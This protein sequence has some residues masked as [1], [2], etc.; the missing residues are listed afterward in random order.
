[1]LLKKIYFSV[2]VFVFFFGLP[3]FVQ[4]EGL[5]PCGNGSDPGNACTLCHLIIGIKGIVDFGLELLITVSAVAIFIAGTMYIISSGSEQMM[6]NAKNFLGASLKGFT[7]VLMAWFFVNLTMWLMSAK[8]DLGI[9]KENWYN[10]TCSTTSSATGSG[11]TSPVY[12]QGGQT[13]QTGGD[14]TGYTY[15]PGIEKQKKDMSSDLS[16]LLNCMQPKLPA[17]AKKISSISDSAGIENCYKDKW[18][19]PVCA[20]ARYSCHYG[21]KTCEMK[22]YATDFANEKYANEIISVAKSCGANYTQNE[23]NHVH[24]S[25]GQKCGCN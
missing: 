16:N 5:V 1:M 8:T 17:D 23:G 18:T 2:L 11:Y 24:V 20:H 9:E 6:G 13:G 10:F 3:F 12:D 14:V 21:G 22:S 19:D 15:D 7:V 25:I 4:A